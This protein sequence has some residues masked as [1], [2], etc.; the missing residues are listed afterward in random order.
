MTSSSL[1]GWKKGGRNGMVNA[2]QA[3]RGATGGSATGPSR[4]GGRV[5][6]GAEVEFAYTT[7]YDSHGRV[8]VN[9]LVDER[10]CAV[11][12]TKPDPDGAG[13]GEDRTGA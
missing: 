10:G 7:G 8:S 9:R 1:V 11:M 5:P 6:W 3:G 4:V 2:A 12:L 13:P